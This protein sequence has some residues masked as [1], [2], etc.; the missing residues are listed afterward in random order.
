MQAN[1]NALKLCQTRI[2]T[3]LP[4]FWQNIEMVRAFAAYPLSDKDLRRSTLVLGEYRNGASF[5]TLP[6]FRQGLTPVWGCSTTVENPLQIH[7]F[8]AK[9][10][11]FAGGA[12]FR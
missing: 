6:F 4:W 11:Q 5:R 9:Q 10:S 7:P 8:Y 2:Y 12:K 1:M 3:G